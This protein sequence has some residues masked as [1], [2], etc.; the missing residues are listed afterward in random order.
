[1]GQSMDFNRKKEIMAQLEPLENTA[2][3]NISESSAPPE[4]SDQ[5]VM[6][7]GE[8]MLLDTLKESHIDVPEDR[9]KPTLDEDRDNKSSS[10]TPTSVDKHDEPVY[11]NTHSDSNILKEQAT[12]EVGRQQNDDSTGDQLMSEESTRGSESSIQRQIVA[13]HDVS[14]FSQDSTSNNVPSDDLQESTADEVTDEPEIAAFDSTVGQVR[15]QSGNEGKDTTDD[16][17]SKDDERSNDSVPQKADLLAPAKT[18]DRSRD[19]EP[20]DGG[21]DVDSLDN[22]D[23]SPMEVDQAE[24]ESEKNGCQ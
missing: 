7:E 18:D 2:S 1:M 11:D 3:S 15:D 17:T 19:K 4:V 8:G 22:K 21:D 23:V 16:G 5:P 13:V 20:T 24:S 9:G 12:D 10:D 14:D 6:E